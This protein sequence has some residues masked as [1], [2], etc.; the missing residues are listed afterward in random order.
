MRIFTCTLVFLT[1]VFSSSKINA[2]ENKTEN[3]SNYQDAEHIEVAFDSKDPDEG[4]YSLVN[5]FQ[6]QNIAISI[7]NIKRNNDTKI[8]AI[9]I[10]MKSDKGETKELH[11]NRKNPIKGIMM[12]VDKVGKPNWDF[13]V[14]ELDHEVN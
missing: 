11:V 1:L 8:I 6:R 5:E 3:S 14:K 9:D 4:I 13:G 10:V 2:Q 7:S 12:Y